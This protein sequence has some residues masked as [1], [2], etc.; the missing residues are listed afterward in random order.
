ML[1]HVLVMLL[2][3]TE[4]CY[5]RAH[6]SE[7]SCVGVEFHDGQA[8]RSS[9]PGDA[10]AGLCAAALCNCGAGLLCVRGVLSLWCAI[11]DQHADSAA[12]D[13]QFQALFH[14]GGHHHGRVP[15]IDL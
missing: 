10:A 4:L 5:K 7:L 2:S 1:S 3:S 11:P 6:R 13:G 9:D 8:N 12:W 15:T 14:P